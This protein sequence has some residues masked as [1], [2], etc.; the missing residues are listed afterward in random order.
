MDQH[1]SQDLLLII[2]RGIVGVAKEI[3]EKELVGEVHFVSWQTVEQLAGVDKGSAGEG[4]R[5][6]LGLTTCPGGV[7]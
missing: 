1:G 2:G 6:A 7:R 4:S 5:A 3:M